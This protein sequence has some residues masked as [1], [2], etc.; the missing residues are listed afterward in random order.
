MPS[1][2]SSLSQHRLRRQGKLFSNAGT[3]D[4]KTMLMDVDLGPEHERKNWDGPQPA[5][6][7]FDFATEKT[8]RVTA[9]DDF[10]WDPCWLSDDE[11]LC[12]IQKEKE[13]EP[14][15]YTMSIEGKNA[16]LIAKH[17]RRPSV[18]AP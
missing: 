15:L 14:S 3:P 8:V 13:H 9:K 6:Y 11:F 2:V 18:S 10:V 16:K 12:L 17:A 4:G 1:F 7:R 5:I